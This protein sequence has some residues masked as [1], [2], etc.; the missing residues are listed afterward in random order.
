MQAWGRAAGR[1][2]FSTTYFAKCHNQAFIHFSRIVED[3][4]LWWNVLTVAVSFNRRVNRQLQA[5]AKN[6]NK[7]FRNTGSRRPVSI[8]ILLQL[9]IMENVTAA[10]I[11]TNVMDHQKLANSA[12]RNAHLRGKT[13]RSWMENSNVGFAACLISELW[14]ERNNQILPGIVGFSKLRRIRTK[15]ERKRGLYKFQSCIT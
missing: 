8:A 5:F 9:F 12:S 3:H 14:L 13:K 15:R 4:S 11:V 6:V 10:M 2:W 7:M 1:V